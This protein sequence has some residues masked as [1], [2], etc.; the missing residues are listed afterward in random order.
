[1]VQ[2]SIPPPPPGFTI[3]GQGAPAAPQR[4]ASP[5]VSR[6]L[7]G[8]PL[9]VIRGIAPDA[10][11]T[12]ARRTP[13]RQAQ[14]IADWERGGRQGVRPATNSRHLRGTAF[15]LAPGP[16]ESMAQLEQRIR[17]SGQ[18]FAEIINEGDH[19][20]VGW[21]GPQV[22]ALDTLGAA[23]QTAPAITSDTP[24]PPT[25]FQIVSEEPIEVEIDQG[26]I[27]RD[28][29]VYD[30]DGHDLGTVSEW[31]ARKR[32]SQSDRLA[33][34]ER[35]ADPMYQAAIERARGG[36][37]AVPERLRAV[38]AGQSLGFNDEILGASEYIFQGLENAGRQVA[39]QPIEISASMASQA[40]RDSERDAQAR[41]AAENPVEN[42]GLQL[43]GGLATPG[44]GAGGNYIAGAQGAARGV[45]AAQVG[46]GYGAAS[47][48]GN[49]TG[50]I[51]ERAPGTGV[52]ALV[53]A[54]TGA[55][56]QRVVDRLGAGAGATQASSQARRLSRE[57]VELTPGQMLGGIPVVGPIIRNAEEAASTVPIAGAA[58]SGARDRATTTFNRAAINRA[59]EPIGE[60]MPT[61]L[62]AFTRPTDPEAG[63]QAVERAQ[64]LV[65]RAYDRALEGIEVR[66]D[67]VFYDDLAE[68]MVNASERMTPQLSEQLANVL[69]NRVFRTL[70]DSDSIMTGD[71]F[72][73]AESELGMLARE[74]RVSLDP[75]NRALASALDD[76]RDV[77]RDLIARQRPD[78]APQ[79]QAV[80]RAYSNLVPVEEAA[81]SR[82]AEATEGVFSP[83]Q[84]SQAAARSQT[85]RT[86]ASGQARMQD[87][88][89]AGRGAINS[90]LGDS[91]TAARLGVTSLM[92]G[93]V[94]AGTLVNP[95]VAVPVIA[96]VSAVY[97][98]PA[99]AALN[100]V[101][102]ATDSQTAT[103]H[104]QQLARL[105]Q[106]DPALIPYYQGAVEHALSLAQTQSQATPPAQSAAPVPIPAQ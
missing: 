36:S 70:E 31:E 87:L 103:S 37:E 8:D 42:F 65:S 82:V 6:A 94:G 33:R 11:I 29:R 50:N 69:Q 90:R 68:V 106:R 59:L 2:S 24:E 76:S 56:G 48:F 72:K 100:A 26:V 40:A 3:V 92:S 44:L 19:I 67:Q 54:G 79:I 47:G 45:R 51:A 71:A 104:L 4:T 25:G 75:A 64:G 62:R 66:P 46:A 30:A 7:E 39:G 28:G 84:L 43:L 88:T 27:E 18:P 15:D 49:A 74:Q 86:R 12:S 101:Y 81:G 89:S 85:R 58:I 23:Q 97:S 21:E 5:R 10:R 63:Y 77:L 96:G 22:G 102:R 9:Q 14:L 98:R 95:A 55:I 38:L 17:G 91:G 52:G 80:N 16:G 13:E 83:T 1:M 105:A 32:Q 99:Q 93:G 57:G 20:H 35:Q 73:R 60:A 34:A 53:G 61:N 78:R 41:Y